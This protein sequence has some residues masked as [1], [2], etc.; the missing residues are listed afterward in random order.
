MQIEQW[1][2][3]VYEGVT[4][5]TYSVSTLGNIRNDSS[6][7]VLKPQCTGYQHV[8]LFHNGAMKNIRVHRV[9]AETFLTK[10]PEHTVVNHINND[11]TDNRVGNLEWAT[12]S[13][14][15]RHSIKMRGAEA[16]G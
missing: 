16:I 8:R 5:D 11:K 7:R 15:V 9:V 14:N 3:M 4:S 10:L 2:K 1:R 6:N 12:Q 13:W